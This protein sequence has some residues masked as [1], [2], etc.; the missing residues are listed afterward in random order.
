MNAKWVEAEP[1]SR[2][3]EMEL[4]RPGCQL[5]C[6]LRHLTMAQNDE[7]RLLSLPPRANDQFNAVAW[8]STRQHLFYLRKNHSKTACHSCGRVNKRD[9]KCQNTAI[10]HWNL[11]VQ[12]RFSKKKPLGDE[13]SGRHV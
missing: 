1:S 7:F 9:R 8:S 6:R 4:S 12:S 11:C 2:W 3:C 10:R 13:R 5:R